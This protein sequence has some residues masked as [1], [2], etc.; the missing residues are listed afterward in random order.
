MRFVGKGGSISLHVIR[1][2]GLLAL[3]LAVVC[4]AWM[5]GTAQATG[6]QSGPEKAGAESNS[7][8]QQET[9]T[10]CGAC[11]GDGQESFDDESRTASLH[12]DVTCVQCHDDEDALETVHDSDAKTKSSSSRSESSKTVSSS[13]CLASKC[14]ESWEALAEKTADITVLTDSEG[15]CVNVHKLPESHIDAKIDCTDCHSIHTDDEVTDRAVE[16]CQRCHHENVYEC[17]TCHN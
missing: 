13:S 5:P 1:L 7:A 6:R 10:V 17:N 9:D 12:L 3:A 4:A 8:S 2:L 16:A 14:H 11:H 15:T